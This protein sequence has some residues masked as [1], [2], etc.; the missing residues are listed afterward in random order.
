MS[1]I[2]THQLRRAIA[3]AIYDDIFSRRNNYYYFFGRYLDTQVVP[4]APS[5]TIEYETTTRNHIVAAKKIYA[6]DVAF[7]V[8]R[9]DWVGGSSYPKYNTLMNGNV[10]KDTVVNATDLCIGATATIL[11][12]G[13]GVTATDFTAIGAANNTIGTTFTATGS[14]TGTGTVIASGPKFYVYDSVNYR[15]YKCIDNNNGVGAS[16]VRPTSTEAYNVTYS[17]GYTWRYMYSLPKSIRNKFLT[18]TH[19][20]VFTALQK[21]YYSD[22][23]LGDITIVKAGANYTQSTAVITVSGDGSGAVLEPVIVNGQLGDI[24]VKNPGR[25]YTRAVLVITDSGS[26]SGAEAV[27]ELNTG[28]LDSDQAL[29]ELLTTSGTVDSVDI[30]DGGSGYASGTDVYVRGDGTGATAQEVIGTNGTITRIIIKNKGEGY[31]RAFLEITPQ[32]LGSVTAADTRVNVSPFLG[33]GRN[34]IDELFAD[35]LMFYSNITSDRLADFDVVTPY[36]QFGII[37]NL[38]NLD[39][40]SNI[41]DQVSP[42]RY[43]VEADFGPQVTFVGGGGV[44]AKGRVNVTGNFVSDVRL[45]SAGAGYISAPT[46]TFGKSLATSAVS[47]PAPVTASGTASSISTTVLTVGGTVTGTFSVGMIVT[48]TGVTAGTY[49]TSFGTGTGGAG[50]YNV[51][52]SQTVSSTAITG[53]IAFATAT[54]AVTQSVA[55]YPVG[56]KIIVT[57]VAADADLTTFN[58]TFTVTACTTTTVSW[59]DINGFANATVQGNVVT[60][61]SGATAFATIDAKLNTTLLT[62]GGVGYLSA[63]GVTLSATN[64]RGG[65]ITA[66]GSSNLVGSLSQPNGVGA[67]VITNQGSGYTNETFTVTFDGTGSVPAAG[68]AYVSGGKVVKVIITNPGKYTTLPTTV[69]FTGGIGGSGVAGTVVSTYTTESVAISK[70][71]TGYTVTPKLTFNGACGVSDIAVDD[72]G[73]G[74]YTGANPAITF[75]GGGGNGLSATAYVNNCVRSTVI[76]NSGSGYYQDGALLPS[77]ATTPTTFTPISGNKLGTSAVSVVKISQKSTNGSGTGATFNIITTGSGLTYNGATTITLASSGSGYAVGNTVTISGAAL[78]GLDSVNDL[79]FTIATAVGALPTVTFPAAG[80]G[81]D[82]DRAKGTAVVS[83]GKVVGITITN[84]GSNYVPLGGIVSNTS[85]SVTSGTRKAAITI[86]SASRNGTV[87]TANFTSQPSAP[88][89]VGSN[90]T[91]AGLTPSNFSGTFTVTACDN[92]SV[93]WADSNTAGA[94]GLSSPTVVANI[95]NKIVSLKATPLATFSVARNA[96]TA[97]ATFVVTQSVA[98]YTVGSKI[99]V[100]GVTPSNFNGT[101]TV[102]ACNTTTV[103]W[104]DTNGAVTATVQGSIVSAASGAK[105]KVSITGTGT[106]YSGVTTI[107]SA[108]AGSGYSSSRAY[109]ISGADLG[110][111]DGTNDLTITLGTISSANAIVTIAA[112]NTGVTAAAS[113]VVTC[114]ISHINLTNPGTGYTSAP[115]I[116]TVENNLIRSA[117]KITPVLGKATGVATVLGYVKSITLTGNGS[118]YTSAPAVVLTGGLSGNT[119]DVSAVAYSKV[120]GEVTSITVDE[121]GAGYT[122]RP[123]VI[124]Y[125]GEGSGASYVGNFDSATG[126]VT[127]PTKV[128]GGSNYVI[129]KFADF[130]IGST[131][132]DTQLNEYVV[133]S[134]KTNLKNNSLII[135]SNNGSPVVGRM[136]IRK[137]NASDYFITNTALSQKFLESRFPVACYK[138]RGAFTLLQYPANTTVKLTDQANGEKTFIVIS[139][140][141]FDT[142]INEMLLMPIDGGTLNNGVTLSNGTNPFSVIS[143]DEPALDRRTGDVLMISNNNSSFT[144]NSDQT[145]SFRTIINF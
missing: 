127:D 37:K 65:A 111:A 97:T 4:D 27:V 7:I 1:S 142:G 107:T 63:P 72:P 53:S 114:G 17:D 110:G 25:D 88:F 141:T 47:R 128:K 94:A 79:T 44:G 99:I 61:G 145:L 140:K 58:G 11:T 35:Q 74:F 54:F 69:T 90:I 109:I 143:Y 5:G 102:T 13:S 73:T 62:Y 30:I 80:S 122:S 129:T 21:R 117:Y 92:V 87:A 8:P 96:T 106:T 125:G 93:Q 3:D 120:V 14:G 20:P 70:I 52:V 12:V 15:V 139:S 81:L 78:G 48:G 43:Q 36:K 34:A 130:T 64:G 57:G 132:I 119:T 135:T 144:Q 24:I 67:V 137:K 23:G 68:T 2:I 121:G 134:A 56:S 112:P 123:S 76:S 9:F 115:I 71:G 131:L 133:H 138:V 18:A 84:R 6:S 116:D 33:H 50:T 31:S 59:L 41:Y 32:S 118:G 45:E 42:N 46:V 89:A 38:R 100:T 49:I 28:D 10:T 105:F 22:G 85:I 75:K 95:T 82:F 83:G 60:S 51:N 66:T 29:V 77:T 108:V 40:T 16:T 98:P 86:N 124:V 104:A 55:P 26:G 113:V 136:T 39:Y 101:F 19:L 103:E 91:V 126:K